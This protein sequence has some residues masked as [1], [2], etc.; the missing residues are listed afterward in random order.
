MISGARNADPDRT[1]GDSRRVLHVITPGDHFSPRTGSATVSVVHGLSSARPPDAPRPLVAVARGTYPDRYASAEVIE[2]EQRSAH[3]YERY[4]DAA[5]ARVALPRVNARARYARA[6]T[7]QA[8]WDPLTIVGHNAVQL[9]PEVDHNRHRPVLY[10]HNDLFRTY[11]RAEAGR[12]LRNVSTVIAVSDFLAERVRSRLPAQIAARVVTV[13]NGVDLQLFQP[14]TD[15]QPQERLRVV[16]VG[17]VIPDKGADVLIDAVAALGRADIALT[18]VGSAGFDAGLPLS[19]YE[20]ALRRRGAESG[21]PIT[22]RPFTPRADLARLL[23][24]SDVVVVPSRWPEPFALTVL[25]GMASGAA[26]IASDTGGIPE[27]TG[28]AGILVRPGD[29]SALAEAIEALA[30]DRALLQAQRERGLA[31][32]RTCSWEA[33]SAEFY[34]VVGQ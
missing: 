22:F 3:R 24:A 15:R 7:E 2:Y 6:L 11:S 10:A 29:S 5:L 19:E 30:S 27:A 18:I 16:F 9:V 31:H 4:T 14:T 17:R 13:R 28:D 12:A 26:V 32:A 8:D 1:A 20:Q 33:A 21:S 34:R 23:S 25:E